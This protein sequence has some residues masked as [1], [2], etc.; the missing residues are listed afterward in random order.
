MAE[1][2][3]FETTIRVSGILHGPNEASAAITA[4]A[5][6]LDL[7]PLV[8]TRLVCIPCRYTSKLSLEGECEVMK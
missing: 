5:T 8:A 3:H 2:N 7:I 6:A 1:A 4:N